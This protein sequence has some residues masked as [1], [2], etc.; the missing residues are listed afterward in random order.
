[1]AIT[2]TQQTTQKRNRKIAKKEI[3]KKKTCHYPKRNR[4]IAKKDIT[5]KKLATTQKRIEE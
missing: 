1:M 2:G 4:I 3:T 5:K